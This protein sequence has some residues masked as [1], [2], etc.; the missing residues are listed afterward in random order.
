MSGGPEPAAASGIRIE[1]AQWAKQRDGDR[2]CK[3]ALARPLLFPER[4]RQAE[5]RESQGVTARHDYA[6][7]PR[8]AFPPTPLGPSAA[9]AAS[10]TKKNPRNSREEQSPSPTH[11]SFHP[12]SRS[13]H[14]RIR[15]AKVKLRLCRMT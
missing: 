5:R 6:S 10:Q 9:R 8:N 13:Y 3:G 2:N 12:K 11:A 7:S 14:P 4:C 15:S 1:R